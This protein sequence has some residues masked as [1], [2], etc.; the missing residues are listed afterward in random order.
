MPMSASFAERLLPR[1]DALVEQ[2]PTPFHVYDERG[3]LNSHEAVKS[4][5]AG[6]DHIQ[7]FAVKALPN[8]AVL[9]SLGEAGSGLDCA[10]LTE[11]QLARRAG[12]PPD[13][14]VYTG[15][16]S[17]PEE[18]KA[19]V[20]AGVNL[21]LDD[22]SSLDHLKVLP[23]VVTFRVTPD[24][25]SAGGPLMGTAGDA[26]FGVAPR[27]AADAYRRAR[28]LGA[29]QFGIHAMTL[30]NELDE[31]RMSRSVE[32]LVRLAVAVERE[33]GVTLEE[34]NIGGG[35]GVPYRP[36][37]RPFDVAQ[38][39]RAVCGMV[40]EAFPGRRLRL[41]TEIGRF[42]TGPH[43]VLVSR[44]I[45][46]MTK[47]REII[48]LDASMS[49]L[50]RP[51]IYGAYHHISFVAE[52]ARRSGIAIRADV[53]GSLC[54]NMDKFA[55]D[56]EL[57]DAAVGDL[58]VIHDTGAHGHAMGFTY[59]GRLRPAEVLLTVDGRFELIRRAESF[60]DYVSTVT[61]IPLAAAAVGGVA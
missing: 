61:R 36:G 37:D 21:T 17:S 11:L 2:V 51:A 44:V 15:N 43:G 52:S 9:T 47:G 46:R 30:A 48:G 54:E 34:V 7:H 24:L 28:D 10:S 45:N 29:R 18:L 56:R 41:R 53:V 14:T 38:F 1:L 8:P 23:P 58:A 5:F 32:A 50:M 59:N 19:A 25:S 55:V 4:A 42:V 12:V 35:L 3:I 49:A 22:P 40:G 13:R 39:G 6:S 60:E 20:D 27:L 33:A 31:G 57:P 16:N 26:K